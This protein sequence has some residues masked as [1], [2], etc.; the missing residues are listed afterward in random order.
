MTSFVPTSTVTVVVAVQS[1]C[2]KGV[3]WL[4]RNL[5]EW[6]LCN[7][8]V[9][10]LLYLHVVL[11]TIA[12]YNCFATMM[13]PIK[14]LNPCSIIRLCTN[15][16]RPFLYVKGLGRPDYACIYMWLIHAYATWVA[17]NQTISWVRWVSENT[18]SSSVFNWSVYPNRF[19][20]VTCGVIVNCYCPKTRTV[21]FNNR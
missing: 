9:L 19:K 11:S 15:V 20:L 1:D 13:Q 12:G 16:T 14:L 7:V 10:V 6:T 8:H 17:S 2:R 18:L 5:I 3:M 4:P 21:W